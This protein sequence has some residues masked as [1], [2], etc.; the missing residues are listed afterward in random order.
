[1]GE[2][3]QPLTGCVWYLREWGLHLDWAA[4]W[5]WL[6]AVGEPDLRAKSRRATALGE[7]AR[8]ASRR[9]LPDGMESWQEGNSA[10]SQ[11]QIQGFEL[12]RPNICLID[13]L[14]ECRKGLVL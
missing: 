13:E 14:L 11:G 1:M 5:S 12:A 6:M 8:A 2:L 3:V 9:A 4:Q 7:L 10:T